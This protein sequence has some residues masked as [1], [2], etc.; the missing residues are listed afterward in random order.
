MRAVGVVS[1]RGPQ[2]GMGKGLRSDRCR[3]T[4]STGTEPVPSVSKMAN[5]ARIFSLLASI[6]TGAAG[7]SAAAAADAAPADAEADPGLLPALADAGLAAAAAL[8]AAAAAGFGAAFG[9][10]ARGTGCCVHRPL[11]RL[12][13]VRARDSAVGTAARRHVAAARTQHPAAL[14][15]NALCSG[16]LVHC[17]LAKCAQ[18]RV[19][20]R[21]RK[22]R[23][24]RQSSPR[25][26]V[27]PSI[28]GTAV[29]LSVVHARAAQDVRTRVI[30]AARVPKPIL[31]RGCET[32]ARRHGTSRRIYPDRR[33]P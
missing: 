7:A 25:G 12:H 26:R 5:A 18:Q 4:H 14:A 16:A 20:V 6:T 19:K 27:R 21:C 10:I 2:A 23:S 30:G 24:S 31:S 33:G 15:P 22:M 29:Q 8:P 9:G 3:Q 32:P 13:L 28:I 11:A 1:A 17:R